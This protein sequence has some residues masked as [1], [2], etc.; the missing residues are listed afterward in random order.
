MTFKGLY[1]AI[2]TPFTA[3]GKLDLEGL[4]ANIRFQIESG[5]DGIVVLGTTGEV[6][7]LTSAEK[8][9]VIRTAREFPCTLIVGTGTYST[10]TTIEATQQAQALGAD[11]VLVVTPYYNKPTQEG[12]YRHFEALHQATNLPIIIYNIQ[13]RTGQN[14]STDCLKRLAQL[15]R[16]VAVK[17][18]SGNINQIMEVLEALPNFT[19]LSGDDALTLPVMALGGHGIISVVSNLVP[20]Q[21]RDLVKACAN[22]DYKAARA[23]HFELLPLFRGAFL[24]TNPSPIKALMNRAG[25]AAGPC[26]LPLCEPTPETLKK[27]EPLCKE[28]LTLA[29]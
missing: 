28:I 8:E 13:G 3:E 18:A 23:L 26:R 5:V 10:H 20:T 14:M 1:T 6:P 2:V 15:P 21:M 11:G 22:E 12:M 4:K 17:E 25:M 9:L 7:T 24:E 16:I 19:V 27:L 29:N